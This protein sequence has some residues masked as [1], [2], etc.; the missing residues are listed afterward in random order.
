[1]GRG[2]KTNG[3]YIKHRRCKKPKFRAENMAK[4]GAV[5]FRASKDLLWSKFFLIN[6][7]KGERFL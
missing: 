7:G 5:S 4:A 6:S 3:I 1:M 2:P